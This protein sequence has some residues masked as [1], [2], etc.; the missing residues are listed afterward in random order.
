[1]QPTL[2][3]LYEDIILWTRTYHAAHPEDT[4][5]E[6]DIWMDPA[7]YRP[8]SPYWPRRNADGTLVDG[9]PLSPR[10]PERDTRDPEPVAPIFTRRCRR[11]PHA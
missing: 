10:E 8:D 11:R 9:P 6:L 5:D 3:S 1:M 2:D 7:V 4:R